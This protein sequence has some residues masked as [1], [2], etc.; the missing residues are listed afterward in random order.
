LPILLGC[1]CE[2]RRR[3]ATTLGRAGPSDG[4]SP[5]GPRGKTELGKGT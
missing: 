4:L 1:P 3:A 2:V 5:P